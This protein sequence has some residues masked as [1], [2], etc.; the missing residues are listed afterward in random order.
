MATVADGTHPTGML[1]CFNFIQF[2]GNNGQN[3]W[4][5]LPLSGWGILDPPLKTLGA[6]RTIEFVEL[7]VLQKSRLFSESVCST[8]VAQPCD[9]QLRL[10]DRRPA[11]R[12][13]DLQSVTRKALFT[14]NVF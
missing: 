1:S 4:L 5:V 9:L 6:V 13:I 11:I 10:H 14:R 8:S 12:L 2:L 7:V 3:S